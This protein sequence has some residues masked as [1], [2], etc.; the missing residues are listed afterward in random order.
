[1]AKRTR[2]PVRNAQRLRRTPAPVPTDQRPRLGSGVE[3]FEDEGLGYG[4]REGPESQGRFAG[5][6]FGQ[7][8]QGD[9]GDEDFDPSYARGGDVELPAD[10]EERPLP[11]LPADHEGAGRGQQG[12]PFAAQEPPAGTLE[13]PAGAM[14]AG[15]GT[16]LAR[17]DASIEEEIAERLA[18]ELDVESVDVTATVADGVVTLEGV[19][20]RTE[21]RESTERR[22]S[23]VA[24]VRAVE[25]RIRLRR[26]ADQE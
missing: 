8:A 16:T 13:P 21:M 19:V 14:A 6:G 7:S 4:R 3:R 17:P 2:R 24:G 26:G 11:G 25:N 1:M 18:D 15:G 9:Y 23:E 5:E 12:T 10:V 20:D 22:A